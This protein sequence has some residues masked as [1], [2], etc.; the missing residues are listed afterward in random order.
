MPRKPVLA[1]QS[2]SKRA[3][4]QPRRIEPSPVASVEQ[5]LLTT[6]EAAKYLRVSV[7]FLAA[8][9]LNERR[10]PFVKIGALVRY[11][12]VALD[13]FISTRRVAA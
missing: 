1:V 4:A 8:D 11:E 7:P 5:K 2:R 10:V 12:K 9:R 3:P 6:P 13:F